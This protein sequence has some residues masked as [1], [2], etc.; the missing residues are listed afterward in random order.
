ML[1]L[2]D[3]PREA[4]PQ[5]RRVGLYGFEPDLEHYVLC[6]LR[7]R[8]PRVAATFAADADQLARV[9]QQLW[10]CAQPPP[11]RTRAPVLWIDGIDTDAAPLRLSPRLWRLATPITGARLVSAVERVLAAL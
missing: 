6:A 4:P 9:R 3:A 7:A 8:W 2:V 5:L 10:L 1:H 11:D